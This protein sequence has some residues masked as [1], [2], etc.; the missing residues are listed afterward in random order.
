[1]VALKRFRVGILVEIQSNNF[2]EGFFP[3]RI[4][5]S[6]KIPRFG[7]LYPFNRDETFVTYDF[8]LT[9]FNGVEKISQ[10]MSDI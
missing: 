2:T 8:N 5:I 9:L 4:T 10:Y 1:M 6:E 7:H 3:S